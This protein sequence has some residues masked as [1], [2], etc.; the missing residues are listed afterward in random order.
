MVDK[1]NIVDRLGVS[2]EELS[3]QDSWRRCALFNERRWI[4]G[5]MIE[6]DDFESLLFF[7]LKFE[8]LVGTEY[9][10]GP[11][12]ETVHYPDGSVQT[13]VETSRGLMDETRAVRG[14]SLGRLAVRGMSLGRLMVPAFDI[15]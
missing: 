14:M 15:N 12:I 1:T 11:Q 9:N 4:Q 13:E 6:L 5:K 2:I 7:K 3:N 8:E 10:F